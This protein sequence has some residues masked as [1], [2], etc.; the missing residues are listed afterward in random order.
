MA[1]WTAWS[2]SGNG[3]ECLLSRDAAAGREDLASSTLE[4]EFLCFLLRMMAIDD[5][6]S[7][8]CLVYVLLALLFLSLGCVLDNDNPDKRSGVMDATA[9]NAVVILLAVGNHSA[10][11]SQIQSR[12]LSH[13]T[14]TIRTKSSM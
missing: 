10:N 11:S 2:Q 12:I 9:A 13:K 1:R 3:E 4:Q 6:G 8:D 14:D 5:C 7:I